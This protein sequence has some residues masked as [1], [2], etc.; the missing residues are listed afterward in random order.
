MQM[1]DETIRMLIYQHAIQLTTFTGHSAENA[2]KVARA[3]AA[4]AFENQ[5]LLTQPEEPA[6][7]PYSTKGAAL[8]GHVRVGDAE[9]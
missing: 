2:L 7:T 5:D 1:N 4:M 3:L 9:D 6:T 8:D